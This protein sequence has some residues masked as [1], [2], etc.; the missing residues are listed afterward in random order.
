MSSCTVSLD[1]VVQAPAVLDIQVAAPVVVDVALAGIPGASAYQIAVANGFVGTAAEWLA[2]LEGEGGGPGLSAYQIA[3]ANGFVGGVAA[4]L[5]SL[6]GEDGGPGLSAYEIA[7]VNGFVGD[8][9][10]WLA[11][12]EGKPGPAGPVAVHFIDPGLPAGTFVTNAVNSTSLTAVAGLA[13]RLELAPFIPSRTITVNRLSVEVTTGVASAQARVG[14]YADAD[15][16]PGE[17]LTGQG[18]L[19]DCA[20]TGA[21]TSDIAGGLVLEAGAKYWLAIHSSSTA[22]LRAIAVGALM[23]LGLPETGTGHNTTRRVTAP[24]ASGLPTTAPAA[25]LQTAGTMPRIALRLA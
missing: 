11:S 13:G 15:G 8:E 18:S 7:V 23:P 16:I 21:K 6:Q 2:S 19:L 12:L 3:V 10:A 1:I 22:T 5:A 24:F 20:T 14:I 4:W 25:A 9:A 17:L